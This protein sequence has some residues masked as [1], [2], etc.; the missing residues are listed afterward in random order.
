MTL[1]RRR[2]LTGS[3]ATAGAATFLAAH[4]ANAQQQKFACE[5]QP[6]RFSAAP[7]VAVSLKELSGAIAAC[8]GR[9]ESFARTRCA[10]LKRLG[11]MTRLDGF[12]ADPANRDVILWGQK[13]K[14]APPLD[15]DDFIIALRAA[16]G[17]YVGKPG[18]PGY[19]L[20]PAISI[21]ADPAVFKRLNE[22]STSGSDY[23]AE[24]MRVCASPQKVRVDGM[25]RHTRVAYTLVDADYRMKQVGQG[26][27]KLPIASP[28]PSHHELRIQL[29]AALGDRNA[30]G[31]Q[32]QST[33]FWFTPGQFNYQISPDGETGFLE[34]A[35]V[36]LRDEDQRNTGQALV[37]SGLTNPIA[38]A[39]TCAWTERMEDVYRAEPIW[40]DMNN[41][42]RHFAVA[43]ILE[44]RRVLERVRVDMR[45][46][47]DTY[48]PEPVKL[49]ET[50]PGLGFVDRQ[51]GQIWS[52][53][54]G[55]SL[56]FDRATLGG[57]E[58][59]TPD[60]VRRVMAQR[61]AVGTLDWDV[62]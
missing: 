57:R 27:L 20:A 31:K 9:T 44:Q 15:F 26:T 47:L 25:P 18:Q 30:A 42:F 38:R 45:V 5:F 56:G 24:Y 41:I 36:I 6:T 60:A 23:D 22:L 49:P 14:G 51:S 10:R 37:A 58:F 53:C 46:L 48:T 11:G 52:I 3:F 39:F 28:F 33:R 16:W 19:N 61:P 54:G 35:Q 55:V 1:S 12:V 62:S 59:V 34:T 50:L 21:D 2:F 29:S 17:R 4:P 8:S 32:P 13:E 43:R 40:R 7:A